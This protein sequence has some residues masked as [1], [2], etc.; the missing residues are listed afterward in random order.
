MRIQEIRQM[1]DDQIAKAL[2]GAYK[3]LLNLRIRLTTKQ[4]SNT[5]QVGKVRKDIARIKT[6]L[7]QRELQGSQ[8]E[9]STT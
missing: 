7:R 9:Q 2:D 1:T 6:I 3:E 4:L 8:R 5:S